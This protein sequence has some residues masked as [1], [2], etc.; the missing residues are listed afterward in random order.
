M[1][2]HACPGLHRGSSQYST[3]LLAGWEEGGEGE[4]G[5]DEREGLVQF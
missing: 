4:Q 5:R 2:L 3:N 1:R